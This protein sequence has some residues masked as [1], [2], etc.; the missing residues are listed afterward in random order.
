M[1]LH[2][3]AVRLLRAEPSLASRLI[4]TLDRWALRQDVNSRKLEERWRQIIDTRDWDAATA[5]TDE[6]QQLRQASPLAT[7]LPEEVRVE[8]LKRAKV[9]STSG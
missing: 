7:L 6:G 9:P 1:L 3:A 2:Q 8:I 5:Q 4:E